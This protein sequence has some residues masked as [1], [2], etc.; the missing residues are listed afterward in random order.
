MQA[1]KIVLI[2]VMA[3]VRAEFAALA[4]E[5]FVRRKVQPK[6]TINGRANG[7]KR[8]SVTEVESARHFA[9]QVFE[10]MAIDQ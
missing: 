5:C 6:P 10:M 9:H 4:A 8:L 1:Q 7:Q 2:T 3:L